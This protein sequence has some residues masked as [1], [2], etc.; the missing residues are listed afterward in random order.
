MPTVTE[1]PK[2]HAP[3]A[4]STAPETHVV[5][6]TGTVAAVVGAGN[7]AELLRRRDAQAETLRSTQA[8]LATMMAARGRNSEVLANLHRKR[9]ELWAKAVAS[10]ISDLGAD[11]KS[12]TVAFPA[13]RTT[14]LLDEI[15][16]LEAI[17]RL[18]NFTESEL[19]RRQLAALIAVLKES[20]T[21]K[22]IAAQYIRASSISR[23]QAYNLEPLE[24]GERE[25]TISSKRADQETQLA[26]AMQREVA[27]LDAKRQEEEVLLSKIP[28]E[29]YG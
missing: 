17:R 5:T 26:D 21:L 4:T 22:S 11:E 2:P 12:A 6:R 28:E 23:M 9:Q 24:Q 7:S 8:A 1:K 19:V 15:R 14:K 10:N 20:A 18:A 13:G 29:T 3:P 16:A 27:A 25:F